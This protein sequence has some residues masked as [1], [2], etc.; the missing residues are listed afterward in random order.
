MNICITLGK[1][2][3]IGA[4]QGAQHKMS[5]SQ[6]SM[7]HDYCFFGEFKL[8][9]EFEFQ[10]LNNTISKCCLLSFGRK[11]SQFYG[12]KRGQ[13]CLLFTPFF[14]SISLIVLLHKI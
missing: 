8:L 4:G 10:T 2:K 11:I 3:G 9:I 5:L 13:F 6:F 14:T 7:R 1:V 12:G